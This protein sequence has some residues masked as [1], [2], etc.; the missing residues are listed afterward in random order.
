MHASLEIRELTA[1]FSNQRQLDEIFPRDITP[2]FSR[3]APGDL[4]S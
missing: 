2:K 1:L 4:A 3:V